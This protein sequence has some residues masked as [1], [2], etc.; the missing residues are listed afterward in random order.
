MRI[1]SAL[2]ISLAALPVSAGNIYK[3]TD[4]QG[5]VHYSQTPPRHGAVVAKPQSSVQ[6]GVSL[7]APPPPVPPSIARTA[8][9][10]KTPAPETAEAKAKRCANSRQRL[11]FLEE[12]PARRLMVEGA[13]GSES[14][15][16]EEQHDQ[17]VAKAQ[18]DGEGC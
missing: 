2:I 18:E 16:T 1:A 6:P 11:Q 8:A 10:E 7:Q 12:N 13:D 9:P 14:R 5:Q 17:N 4:A 15:M 3:W